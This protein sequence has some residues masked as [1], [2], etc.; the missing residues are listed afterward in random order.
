MWF[1]FQINL[2]KQLELN[3]GKNISTLYEFYVNQK[4]KMCLYVERFR[5][6]VQK[7]AKEQK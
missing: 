1:F 6:K 2:I 5:C 4:I 7:A 3:N